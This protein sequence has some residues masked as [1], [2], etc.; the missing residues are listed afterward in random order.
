MSD[1][2]WSQTGRCRPPA[3]RRQDVRRVLYPHG[4]ARIAVVL[5]AEIS[6]DR[7]VGPGVDIHGAWVLASRSCGVPATRPASCGVSTMLACCSAVFAF[8][9]GL[10]EGAGVLIDILLGVPIVWFAIWYQKRHRVELV[11]PRRP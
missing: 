1:A 10:L 5:A 6:S 3:P 7:G 9:N 2:S 4:G 8:R 11:A